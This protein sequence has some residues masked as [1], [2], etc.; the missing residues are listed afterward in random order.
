MSELLTYFLGFHRDYG[1]ITDKVLD[2]LYS[3][4]LS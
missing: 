3:S 1:T 2:S 4:V